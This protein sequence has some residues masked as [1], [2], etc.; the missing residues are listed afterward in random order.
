MD[1]K[2]NQTVRIKEN[3]ALFLIINLYLLVGVAILVFTLL[4]LLF[5]LDE[6]DKIV[7]K[8]IP[9][10]AIGISSILIYGFLF[11]KKGRTKTKN[12]LH[13]YSLFK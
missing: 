6:S 13:Y 5:H 7:V 9:G 1:D 2:I 12:R 4:Y 11:V 8:C 10:F 3:K